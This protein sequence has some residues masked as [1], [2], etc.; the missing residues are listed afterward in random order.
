MLF[1]SQELPFRQHLLDSLLFHRQLHFSALAAK[2]LLLARPVDSEQWRIAIF[3][4]LDEHT[5]QKIMRHERL[6]KDEANL[7]FCFFSLVFF[8]PING[9]ILEAVLV[10]FKA[11]VWGTQP[12]RLVPDP[13]IWA[14]VEPSCVK[15]A[16][17]VHLV[18]TRTHTDWGKVYISR[19]QYRCLISS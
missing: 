15:A 7:L 8:L 4:L 19:V 16:P 10:R 1:K 9:F 17:K 3:W 2:Q 6:S 14:P 13:S 11:R 5:G 18:S 12:I